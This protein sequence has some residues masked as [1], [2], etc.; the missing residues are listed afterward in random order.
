MVFPQSTFPLR[1]HPPLRVV[2][3]DGQIAP[4]ALDVIDVIAGEDA[5]LNCGHMGAD[6]I[7]RVIPAAVSA[8]VTKIV[9]SH[10]SFIVG[11]SPERV[12]EWTRLGATIEHCAAMMRPTRPLTQEIFD[13][14]F[15]SSG[16]GQTVLSSDLGQKGNELPVTVIRRI[17]RQL[18]DN[19]YGASVV[20]ALTSANA[21]ALLYDE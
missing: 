1:E 8:G 12:L 2:D 3:E 20:K 11:A 5:I 9:V 16:A 7:D 19:G 13:R 10:P 4:A 18:L 21:A 15:A 17:A 14:Y 6:E